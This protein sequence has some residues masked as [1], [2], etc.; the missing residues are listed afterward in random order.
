MLL[1][2]PNL[3]KTCPIIFL[4][5]MPLVPSYLPKAYQLHL[6]IVFRLYLI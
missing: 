4:N 1:Y 2:Q 6:V 5:L 3:G